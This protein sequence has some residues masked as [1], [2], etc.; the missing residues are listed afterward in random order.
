MS[1]VG[2]RRLA[3]H[4]GPTVTRALIFGSPAIGAGDPDGCFGDA[5][6]DGV[7]DALPM[8]VDQRGSGYWRPTDGDGD[9][10]AR[11]DIGAVESQIV[12]ADGFES[13]TTSAWSSTVP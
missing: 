2:L 9:E 1:P 5:N 7:L 12:F 11:C 13:G 6:G 3:N 8:V 10:I 4:G